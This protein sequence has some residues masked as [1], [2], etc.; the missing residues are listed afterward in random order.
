MLYQFQ[1]SYTF[2][3]ITFD[4]ITDINECE[5][6]TNNCHGDATCTNDDGSF[7]CNCNS[8]YEGDGINCS[9]V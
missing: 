7:L 5:V 9:S 4:T 8:G 3:I 2:Y 6:G 1:V